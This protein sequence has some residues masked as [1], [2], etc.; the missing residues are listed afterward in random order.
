MANVTKAGVTR[1]KARTIEEERDR[2]KQ[3]VHVKVD[4]EKHEYYPE[5]EHN[6]TYDNDAYQRVGVYVRVSTDEIHQSLSYEL[7][8]TYYE[9]FVIRHP[10]WK[11]VDI[12]ADEGISGT[13]LKHR[14][15]FNRMIADAKAGK[16]D[17][18]ITKSV[19]RFARNV[20]D[21]LGMVRMLAEH[22]PA[23]GVFFEAECIYSLNERSQMALSFQATMAEEESRN[24]SRSMETSLRMRLDHGLPLTPEL[25]GYMHDEDGHLTP[26][27]D[28]AHIPKLIFFMYLY[29][30][31]TTQIA[32]KLTALGKK[33]YRG[34]VK[35]S[36]SGIIQTLKNER[37]CGDVFTR[38][39]FT[40]DVISHR[41]VK[42][43]GQRPRSRYLDWHQAIVSR[44]DYIAVQ[45]ML[46]NAKYGNKSILPELQVIQDGLLKGYVIINPRW[47]AFTEADYRNA[48]ASAYDGC[49]LTKPS[50]IEIEADE[51]DFDFSGYEIALLDLI[52]MRGFPMMYLENGSIKFNSD[53]IKKMPTVSH[54]ELLVHPEM[55]AIAIRPAKPDNRHAVNWTMKSSGV[56]QP[57]IISAAA[58]SGVLFSLFGWDPDHRYR[59]YG[60]HYKNNDEETMIFTTNDAVVMI[61]K[62]LLRQSAEQESGFRPLA[63]TA[64]RVG[65][66]AGNMSQSFGKDFY[67]EQ[68]AAELVRQTKENW[69]IRLEGRLCNSGRKLKITPYE[70]LKAFIQE[71]LGDLF[72]EDDPNG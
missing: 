52:N 6:E 67:Q 49:I 10:K 31:S 35:W 55:K 7:Q 18:I 65:A 28:T 19:S 47:G 22:N 72:E 69:Q 42:N 16:I 3:R 57:R 53:S 15:E 33:T 11:L 66:V 58:F 17:L 4:E 64:T 71:Q 27:P 13:S 20:V 61:R 48:S 25:L 50:E 1:M 23:I 29:G 38:K 12:Y 46:Q 62:T 24:K 60:S 37:Y 56:S 30:Y 43:R 45:H 44:D 40:P 70:E 51:G 26:N 32:E 21:F 34:N 2:V 39:T 63:Q 41:S 9:D 8:K 36:P 5:T 14:D 68:T 54:V 59:L